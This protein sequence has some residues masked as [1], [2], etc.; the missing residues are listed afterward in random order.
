M[1][2]LQDI[3]LYNFAAPQCRDLYFVVD[4][5]G[6]IT[7]DNQGKETNKFLL[8]DFLNDV[9]DNVFNRG[10]RPRVGLLTFA[11]ESVTCI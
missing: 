4:R 8:V 6:S 2:T 1:Y 10:G 11:S 7:G 5:S 9:I 3:F